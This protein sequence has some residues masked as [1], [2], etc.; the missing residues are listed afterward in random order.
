MASK[1]LVIASAFLCVDCQAAVGIGESPVDETSTSL[2]AK[3]K[4][5]MNF[6]ARSGDKGIIH[7][8]HSADEVAETRIGST[9]AGITD[10]NTD[11]KKSRSDTGGNTD[12]KKIRSDT[13]T[14]TDIT[15]SNSDTTD[16]Y[17]ITT[18]ESSDSHAGDSNHSE[19]ASSPEDK[20]MPSLDCNSETESRSEKMVRPKTI[21]RKTVH[22]LEIPGTFV[23]IAAHVKDWVDI[24]LL[25][26][27]PDA[28]DASANS[29]KKDAEQYQHVRN[30]DGTRTVRKKL[31]GGASVTIGVGRRTC[32]DPGHT[33]AFLRAEER[34]EIGANFSRMR[35]TVSARVS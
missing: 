20:Q 21:P 2:K 8:N 13:D 14:N 3:G 16:I 12:I 7:D 30:P 6:Q 1:S 29:D 28:S 15:D 26:S 35:R 9:E 31:A 23:T 18:E 10:S 19:G 5:G 27:C 17:T 22:Y 24:D 32:M 25:N 34:S 4:R 33:D 11:I